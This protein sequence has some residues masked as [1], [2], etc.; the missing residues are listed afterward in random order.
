[1]TPSKE[2]TYGI[3]EEKF[4]LCISHTA[5]P[6][7]EVNGRLSM[8]FKECWLNTYPIIKVGPHAT[9]E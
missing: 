5:R 7:L 3:C 4:V 2:V 8:D 6:T 1:M 9:Q